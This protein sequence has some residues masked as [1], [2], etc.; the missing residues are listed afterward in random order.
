M[1]IILFQ[2]LLIRTK[3]PIDFYHVGVI[4]CNSIND[5]DLREMVFQNT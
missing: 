1:N 2:L 5:K 3:T 4:L